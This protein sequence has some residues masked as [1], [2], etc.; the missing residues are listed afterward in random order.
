[1]KT[2]P[3]RNDAIMFKLTA[4]EKRKI[5]E[6]ARKADQSISDYCRKRLLADVREDTK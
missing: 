2:R 1:M 4:E 3:E 6:L 5:A